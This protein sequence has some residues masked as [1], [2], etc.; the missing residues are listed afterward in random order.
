MNASL[1]SHGA[2]LPF[3]QQLLL[4]SHHLNQK[5][6]LRRARNINTHSKPTVDIAASLGR[7]KQSQILVGFALETDDGLKNASIN[8]R[9]RNL[10]L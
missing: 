7:S 9:E 8:Y 2:I 4:I 3:C 5:E 1:I 10:I 6:K